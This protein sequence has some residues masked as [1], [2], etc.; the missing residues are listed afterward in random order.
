VPEKND[1]P[2]EQRVCPL[3]GREIK[4]LT[5]SKCEI[6]DVVPAKIIVK[7][8]LDERVACP[9]DDAIVS[10]PTPPAIVERGVLGDTLIVE[11]LCDKYI[12]HLPVERQCMRFAR[13]GVDIAPNTLGRS[14]RDVDV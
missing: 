2:A 1:V 7:E 9:H 10:A 12:E 5:Y 13:A 6:F 4:S 14:S 8:R 3:C 11:A